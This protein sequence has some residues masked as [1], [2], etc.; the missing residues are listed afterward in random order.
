LTALG[1]WVRM[2]RLAG[3]G[4]GGGRKV[5]L[6]GVAPGPRGMAEQRDKLRLLRRCQDA[7][8]GLRLLRGESATALQALRELFDDPWALPENLAVLVEFMDHTANTLQRGNQLINEILRDLLHLEDQDPSLR[9]ILMTKLDGLE[10][11][12]RRALGE[13]RRLAELAAH[14]GGARSWPNQ[15]VGTPE[16]VAEQVRLFAG[17]GYRH[18]VA[19]F[20]APVDAESMERLANEVRPMVEAAA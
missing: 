12:G 10:A 11:S 2:R 14:N 17:I 18:L 19:G 4:H 15:L 20:P 8:D 3:R 6:P 13:V 9:S 5:W 7:L 1:G 16:Q